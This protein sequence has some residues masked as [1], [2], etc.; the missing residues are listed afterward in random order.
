MLFT[1]LSLSN[2]NQLH[3]QRAQLQQALSDVRASVEFAERLLTCGSDAEIL[4]AK[5]VTLRRLTSLAESSYD[6]NPAAVAPD[7]GSSISFLPREPAG[8]V[9]GYP[10]VGV[11]NSKTV[12]LS[13]CTIEGE[14]KNPPNANIYI[15]LRLI[16]NSVFPVVAVACNYFPVRLWRGSG[17]DLGE[18]FAWSS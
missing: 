13:K 1:L 12:D 10:V 7:D 8:E 6:A 18:G 16:R 2:R 5:G 11:I 4:S 3:L 14:G 9:E 17:R 15:L